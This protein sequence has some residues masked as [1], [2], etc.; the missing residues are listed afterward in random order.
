MS[1]KARETRISLL[2]LAP[3][4]FIFTLFMVYPIFYS[5]Y[6]S[7]HRFNVKAGF[8]KIPAWDVTCTDGRD[9]V[10]V[11]I[12]AKT[13]TVIRYRLEKGSGKGVPASDRVVYRAGL[14]E[15][16]GD[17][18]LAYSRAR[19]F[20]IEESSYRTGRGGWRVADT[21]LQPFSTEWVGPAN[22][23]RLLKDNAF[24]WSLVMTVLY[25]A[26]AIPFG[27]TVA[28]CLALLLNNSLPGNKFFRSAYF[29]PNVLDMLAVGFVWTLLYAAGGVLPSLLGQIGIAYF[30]KT[31][32]LGNPTT[33]LPAIVFAMTLKGAG[34]GMIL[35][36]AA[37]QNIDP[38]LHEAAAI[39]GAGPWQRIRH[40]TLPLLKPVILFMVVTGAIGAL[41]A[42]TEV[43]AMT[44]GGPNCLVPHWI[45]L[46]GGTTQGATK[47][48][49]YYLYQ[50]FVVNQEY[51]FGAS[52]AYVLL[53]ITIVVTII[54]LK[55]FQRE[56]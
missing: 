46:F 51:G 26:L 41:N 30:Q 40:I 7:F 22:Y 32:F 47:V 37:L 27:I 38:S 15:G 33:A 48:S 36:L 11:K 2:F 28:F 39:D 4:L 5:L 13:G 49:G 20:A 9:L 21:I 17:V 50:K 16:E 19:E 31:G 24:W 44:G 23:V 29:L 43:Y 45:P 10:T 3:F 6:L 52:I 1:I 42:F 14:R 54:N 53:A 34:F 55:V 8:G 18:F 35:F 56:R 25:G 12:D